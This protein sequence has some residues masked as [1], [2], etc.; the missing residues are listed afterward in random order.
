MARD[1]FDNLDPE[2][3][4]RLFEAA[5]DEFSSHGFEGASLNRIIDRAG[6]SKGSLYYYFNDKSDLFAT[7]VERAT[8]AVMKR[9]GGFSLDDLTAETFWPQFEGA[10]RRSADFMQRN[11]WFVKLGRS[12]Y[13]LRGAGGRKATKRVFDWIGSWTTTILA[14]G[15]QL[16]V[17]RTDLP[18]DFLVE[19]TLAIGETGDRWLLTRWHDLSPAE[20]ERTIAAEMDA[21]HRLLE[22]RP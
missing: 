5:A 9:V 21:F 13:R 3:Q 14:R 18:L 4:H 22:P 2:K 1:R 10:V 20:R 11:E 19:L 15:Q 16:G 7:V 17:V 8:A 6:M 12:F